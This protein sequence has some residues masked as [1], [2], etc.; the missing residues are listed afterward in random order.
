MVTVGGYESELLLFRMTIIT[1][2]VP[3]PADLGVGLS[4]PL[5]LEAVVRR[6]QRLH[7]CHLSSRADPAEPGPHTHTSNPRSLGELQIWFSVGHGL[8]AHG[9]HLISSSAWT[10]SITPAFQPRAT[11]HSIPSLCPLCLRTHATHPPAIVHSFYNTLAL[12]C[13]HVCTVVGCGLSCTRA[14]TIQGSSDG[15]NMRAGGCTMH[16]A[17]R[18]GSVSGLGACTPS[19]NVPE[20]GREGKEG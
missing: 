11:P 2:A 14:S 9:E 16:R 10:Y 4:Q 12:T 20:R 19:R 17:M 6:K 7:R 15:V 8:E 18:G 1:G 5:G 3:W 13:R